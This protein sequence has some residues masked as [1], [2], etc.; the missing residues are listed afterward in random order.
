MATMIP[1]STQARQADPSLK[2]VSP[3]PGQKITS[4]NIE[5][6][7]DLQNFMLDCTKSGRPDEDGIG[8]IH[9]MVDGMSMAQLTNFYCD[10]SFTIPGDGLAPG[11]H[12]L[13]IVLATNTHGGL[14][15]SAQKVEIDFQ[16]TN[17][18]PLPEGNF[19]GQPSIKLVSPSDGATVPPKFTVEVEPVNF[20]PT[21]ALEG[22]GNVPGY[23]HFHV[24]VDTPMDGM[25]MMEMSTPIA[26]TEGTPEG[27]M[28]NTQ[29]MSMAG[30][31]A[32][33]GTKSFELDLIAWGP[34][35]HTIWIEPVQNDHTMFADFGHVE[36]TVMMDENATPAS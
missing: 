14:M 17:P 6:T 30:M 16:P 13:M 34:G 32:M 1:L 31:V 28:D 24:F 20:E 33:P 4:E 36:F 15:K 7:I 22:K 10:K 29:M 27:A 2:I 12:T 9:A 35:K 21:E 8:H 11:K 5:V 25:G 18:V 3:T 23:G 26:A 19:T